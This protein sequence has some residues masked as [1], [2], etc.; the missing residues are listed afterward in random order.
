MA[1]RTPDQFHSRTAQAAIGVIGLVLSYLFATRAIDT[2]SW[3]QYGAAVLLLALGLKR[4][5]RAI[6]KNA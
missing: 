5:A 4:I 3:I 2:G 6:D 1:L